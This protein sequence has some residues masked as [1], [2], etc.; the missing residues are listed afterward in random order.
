MKDQL[1][2]ALAAYSDWSE[3]DEQLGRHVS[4]TY[5]QIEAVEF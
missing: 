2:A 1:A 4:L 3:F 5:L